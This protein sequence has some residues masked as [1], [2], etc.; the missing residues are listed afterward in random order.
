MR[1]AAFVLLLTAASSRALRCWRTASVDYSAANEYVQMHYP[2]LHGAYFSHPRATVPIH[3]ARMGVYSDAAGK[4]VPASLSNCGF[5][6]LDQTPCTSVG[7]WTDA[8][9]VRSTYLPV[10]RRLITEAVEASDSHG[11]V[12][13]II[14]WH[15]LMRQQGSDYKGPADA[16]GDMVTCGPIAAMAHVDTD[17]NAYAGNKEQLA[18]IVLAN[19]V[20][21]P[22]A[23]P[24]DSDLTRRLGGG[25]RFCILNA[26]RNAD[27]ER[28]IGRAPL[29]LLAS[30]YAEAD[31]LLARFPEHRLDVRRSR[32][33]A[34]PSMA[35]EVLLFTQ[36]D[37]KLGRPSELWH[38]ALPDLVEDLQSPPRR[39][40]EIRALV[41]LDEQLPPHLDR[42]RP[43]A[44]SRPVLTHK[45]SGEFCDAQACKRSQS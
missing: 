25:R 9:F 20:V 23:A 14:F 38:C 22:G 35:D 18:R 24:Y 45:Q 21:E 4:L 10:L 40:L 39:S 34:F 37:R 19:E 1:R 29:A 26:W 5:A 36:Y 11:K 32:W 31:G 42:W 15:M 6:L 8:A 13:E 44:A 7:D 27:G 33:Y 16:S 2:H 12:S 41:I 30:Q 17:M 3:N 43:C 28:P